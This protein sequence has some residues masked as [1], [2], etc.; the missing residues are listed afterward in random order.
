MPSKPHKFAYKRV[1]PAERVLRNTSVA[2][3]LILAVLALRTIDTPFTNRVTGA[4]NQA[5]S[6][7]LSLDDSL[8]QLSFVENLMPESALV[9]FHVGG[10]ASDTLPVQGQI[11][12]SWSVGQPWIEYLTTNNAPVRALKSGS[13]AAASQS[14]AGDWTI[15]IN[16]TD[17]S[18]TVYAYLNECTVKPGDSVSEADEIGR[19]GTDASAHLYFEYRVNSEPANPFESAALTRS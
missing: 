5:I 13:V 12:H 2:C 8:G 9:F 11:A 14:T 1:T 4:L 3:A 17:G 6:M 15:L 16:H 10:K 18:Q 7:D 19:T